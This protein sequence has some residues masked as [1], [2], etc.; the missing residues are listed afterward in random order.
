MNCA[1]VTG[2]DDRNLRLL[3]SGKSFRVDTDVGKCRETTAIQRDGGIVCNSAAIRG[4]LD[5]V[6][7]VAPTNA[8]VL[9]LGETGVGKEVFAQAI[10]AASPRQ[11]RPM[12]RVNCA[13]IPIT[14][15]ESELFGHERGAFTDAC[16]RQIGRFEAA[17]GST[18][19]LDEIGE[20]PL[21]MQV[22]LLRVVQDRTLERLG[23]TRSIKIDV[24][25]IA[26]TNRNLEEAVKENTFREDLFYRLNV[27]PIT[28]PA[29][30]ERVTDIPG[31]VWSFIDELAPGLG[32]TIEAVS[33]R[34]LT[35]LQ[36]YGWPG[37]VRE[38][39]NVIER[40]LILSRGTTFAPAAPPPRRSSSRASSERLID[41]QTA[42]IR[43]VLESCG[44]RVRG[45]TGAAKRLGLKPTT[46]E[47]QMARLGIL[48]G[49]QSAPLTMA[50]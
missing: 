9:L 11:H 43:S 44:W 33:G 16:A 2:D 15:M 18:L 36:R 42:H 7:L 14:L 37:N 29:L 40:E 12:I 31:L 6:H 4:V 30:R 13:A 22:K 41:V 19:F 49:K 21:E 23:G 26:A 5:Q 28:I 45:A 3:D 8:T 1:A 46:L 20:L 25:I 32:K 48:R 24:R 35:E 27:F 47:S 34:S 17:N 38:L 50:V 10:H 39:R